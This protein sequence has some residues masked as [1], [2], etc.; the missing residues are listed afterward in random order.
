MH[1][2]THTHTRTHSSCFNLH[3]PFFFFTL[4]PYPIFELYHRLIYR[5]LLLRYS[6]IYFCLSVSL[7]LSL[8]H[9]HTP[10][11]IH[12]PYL[13]LSHALS[14]AII[15]QK[16]LEIEYEY[17]IFEQTCDDLAKVFKRSFSIT[18]KKFDC[19]KK[20]FP[21][22]IEM[23]KIRCSSKRRKNDS[24]RFSIKMQTR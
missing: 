18:E 11:L 16:W 19:L 15:T 21:N 7:F 22:K 23:K 14:S 20:L 9:I 6:S 4:L 17:L 12:S 10:T 5:I 2:H 8:T 1:T 3:A 24:C 13:S